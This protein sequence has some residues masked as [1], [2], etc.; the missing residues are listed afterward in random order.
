MTNEEQLI[1]SEE[2]E[3][4]ELGEE[5][6]DVSEE[7]PSQAA[8]TQ[9]DDLP[10]KF[11]GKT[12]AEIAKSAL[13][14]ERSMHSTQVEASSMRQQLQQTQAMIAQLQAQISA[15]SEVPQEDFDVVLEREWDEDPKKA[16]ANQFKRQQESIAQRERRLALEMRA[17]QGIEYYHS[18]KASNPDFAEREQDMVSL[19]QKYSFLINPEFANSKEAM[20]VLHLMARGSKVSDYEKAAVERIKKQQSQLKEEKRSAVS[21]RAGAASTA[22]NAGVDMDDFSNLSP[23]QMQEELDRLS[24]KLGRNG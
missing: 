4:S 16:V 1:S 22:V 23:R 12:A 8:E 11:K 3:I 10:E 15:R 9:S 14:A 24:R 21:E 2:E 19:S 20:E 13:E 18:A 5:Q 7:V 17:K 6:T